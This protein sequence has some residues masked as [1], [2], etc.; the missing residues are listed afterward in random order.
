MTSFSCKKYRKERQAKKE[1]Y[2]IPPEIL[3]ITT[4]TDP[5]LDSSAN[6]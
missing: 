5:I 2:S 3:L 1:T 6:I 4:S